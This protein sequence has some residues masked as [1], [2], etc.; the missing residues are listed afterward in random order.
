MAEQNLG[1]LQK[2]V[3]NRS[4]AVAELKKIPSNQKT[5]HQKFLVT[6][7]SAA[8]ESLNKYNPGTKNHAGKFTS[9]HLGFLHE[10]VQR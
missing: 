4:E 3:N 9:W 6:K 1:A 8:V 7:W 5:N 2:W 10:I